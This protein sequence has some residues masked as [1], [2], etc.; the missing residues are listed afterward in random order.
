MNWKCDCVGPRL[1]GHDDMESLTTALIV[2]V[3]GRNNPAATASLITSWVNSVLGVIATDYR[4][5]SSYT[6]DSGDDCKYLA[7]LEGTHC[8]EPEQR[9]TF[10]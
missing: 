6:G 2:A 4:H 9:N 1:K 7:Q 5:N 8:T 10:M 3:G